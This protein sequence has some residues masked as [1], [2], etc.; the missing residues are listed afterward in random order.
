MHQPCPS[1]HGGETLYTSTQCPLISHQQNVLGDILHRGGTFYAS[2]R[3]PQGT[4]YPS[5]HCPGEHSTLVQCPGGHNLGGHLTLLQRQFVLPVD[6][7]RKQSQKARI[8]HREPSLMLYSPASLQSSFSNG[9]IVFC[10][11]HVALLAP[12]CYMPGDC[13]VFI[14]RIFVFSEL[15]RF[16]F[17]QFA[18]PVE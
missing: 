16:C 14:S 7:R 4:F 12:S 11:C 2:V 9:I 5:V 15:F 13:L 1:A 17:V 10:V 18:F 3:C 6:P 8:C